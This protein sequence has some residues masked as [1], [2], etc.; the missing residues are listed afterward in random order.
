MDWTKAE[1]RIRMYQKMYE[2]IGPSGVLGLVVTI[3]PLVERFEKGERTEDLYKAINA[4][5]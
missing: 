1:E 2:G 3:N 4:V 5:E